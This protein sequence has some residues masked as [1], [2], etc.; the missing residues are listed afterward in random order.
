MPGGTQ[1]GARQFVRTNRATLAS[2]AHPHLAATALGL[3]YQATALTIGVL[4]TPFLLHRLGPELFGVWVLLGTLVAYESIS[5]LGLPAAMVMY[6]NLS[7]SADERNGVITIG[8]TANT[9]LTLAVAL[10]LLLFQD[11]VIGLFLRTDL[12]SQE[13]LSRAYRLTLMSLGFLVVARSFSSILDAH[14]RVDIRFVTD[15]V[16]SVCFALLAWQ[17]VRLQFGLLGVVSAGLLAAILRAGLAIGAAYLVNPQLRPDVAGAQRFARRVITYG[18]KSQG[19]NIG[20]ALSDPL[21]KGIIGIGAGPASAGAVQM[22]SSVS[23]VPNAVAH[24]SIANLFP[25]IAAAHGQGDRQTIERL[26]GRYLVAVACLIVPATAMI[27]LVAEDLINLW[28]GGSYPEVQLTLRYTA[29]AFALRAFAMVPWRVTWGLGRPEASSV[30]MLLHLGILAVAG[31]VLLA[32]PDPLLA[33][34]LLLF[35]ISYGVSTVYLFWRMFQSLPGF[36][37]ENGRRL[38]E[39][40]LKIVVV[41]AVGSGLFL[42]SSRSLPMQARLGEAVV[43]AMFAIGISLG[44]SAT[45]EERA[46]WQVRLS[47]MLRS[48]LSRSD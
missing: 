28:L 26:T 8:T 41:T 46:R 15:I 30:A 44:L 2:A 47:A 19:A 38:V 31:T 3:A 21:L 9:A 27:V 45:R 48:G 18:L 13:A 25:A 29:L 22:G 12:L 1:P 11:D 10:L 20:V 39:S 24:S 32:T 7:K 43:V 6:I 42:L 36:W 40:G 23:S 4:L 33:R 37:R 34:M 16:G 14:Q 35:V 17:A 5:D